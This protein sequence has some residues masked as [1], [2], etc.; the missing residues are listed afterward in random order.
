MPAAAKRPSGK[1]KPTAAVDYLPEVGR[2]F[3]VTEATGDPWQG[4]I[5]STNP[6]A[7]KAM[8]K[9]LNGFPGAGNTKPA[10]YAQ[11]SREQP[12]PKRVATEDAE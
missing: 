3:W 12:L 8:L 1:T 9:I 5:I 10:T 2:R 6:G 7:K 4:T 11:L